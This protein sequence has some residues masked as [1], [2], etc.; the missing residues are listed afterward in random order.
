M[1][2]LRTL[3]PALEMYSSLEEATSVLKT[4]RE[5][6]AKAEI[7]IPK[8]RA[9]F[10]AE[11]LRQKLVETYRKLDVRFSFKLGS[12]TTYQWTCS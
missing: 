5:K 3:V 8:S 1:E 6:M 7:E 4:A 11:P 2:E 12:N 10:A 9:K